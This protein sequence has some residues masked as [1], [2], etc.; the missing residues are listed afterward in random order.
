[1]T[2]LVNCCSWPGGNLSLNQYWPSMTPRPENRCVRYF[3]VKVVI[4]FIYSFGIIIILFYC[5]LHCVVREDGMMREGVLSVP[6][7]GYVAVILHATLG[8]AGVSTLGGAS[9]LT[10]CA[11]NICTP[12]GGAPGLFQSYCNMVAICIRDDNRVSPIFENGRIGM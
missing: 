8:D 7:L 4:M 3:C 10:L 5:D 2:E 12:I 9:S 11:G 6:T 1:M